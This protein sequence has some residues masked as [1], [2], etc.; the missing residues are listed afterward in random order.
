M[1]SMKKLLM[2]IFF[3]ITTFL[4]IGNI[5]ALSIE[6]KVYINGIDAGF[7][8]FAYMDATGTPVGFDIDCVEWIAD[9]MGFEVKH[10]P[11]AWDAIIPSLQSKTIDFI[12]SGLSITPERLKVID[13]TI[14]YFSHDWAVVTHEDSDL[15]V[16]TVFTEK[17]TRLAICRGTSSQTWIEKE[18]IGK[19]VF[20]SDQFLNVETS[21][22]AIELVS[23]KKADAA[24]GDD[25]MYRLAIK[26]KPLKVVGTI[27]SGQDYAY[28]VRKED[29]ELKE[30]LNEG[31]RRLMASPKFNEL[32]AKWNV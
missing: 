5:G 11:I 24:I 22:M 13:Y 19:G 32:K 16:V 27:S 20:S 4:I 14:P 7:V 28:G 8:P 12:A 21:I 17:N 3:L 9:E 18:L 6:K 2:V 10:M 15:S 30:M 31:L 25:G 26:N 29:Q 1:K 23:N